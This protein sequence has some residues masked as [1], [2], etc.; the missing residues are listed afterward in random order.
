MKKLLSIGI[1]LLSIA[2]LSAQ[3]IAIEKSYRLMDQQ[4]FHPQ[5]NV[6]GNM[7]AFTTESYT[8]LDVYNFS[9]NA[10][11]RVSEDPGAGFQPVFSK[12]SDKVFFK[13]IIYENRLRKEGIKSYEFKNN[14]KVTMLEPRRN[15]KQPQAFENGILIYADARLLK[16]T[17][18]RTTT[19]VN[20]YVWSDG[21]NLNIY[22]DN[23]IQRLNPVGDAN[24]YIWASLSPNWKMILFTAAG[25][26]TF[27]SDLNGKII[28]K[29][30]YLNAPA[31]YNDNMVVG[32]QDKD[33]GEYVTESKILMKSIDGKVEKVLSTPNQIAMYPTAAASAKKVAYNTEK[34]EIYVVELK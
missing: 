27:V 23:K 12:S 28:A 30:G 9:N 8:G 31:W 13:N 5:F 4:G 21:S 18:G 25:T 11:V 24:G 14:K 32:M 7:L 17:F 2:T 34:G 29:L 20:D 26:G 3:T 6:T 1:V 22:R 19:P 16:A 33:N 15:I 10:V